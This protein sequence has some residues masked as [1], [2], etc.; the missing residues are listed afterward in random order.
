MKKIKAS[1]EDIYE[2]IIIWRYINK[3]EKNDYETNAEG[4]KTDPLT[5]EE[6][7]LVDR[8]FEENYGE[9]IPYK[10]HEIYKFN[11][12]VFDHRYFPE[13]LQDSKLTRYANPAGFTYYFE[14]KNFISKI[15]QIAGVKT[16]EVVLYN[17]S[18]IFY[19]NKNQ[20]VSLEEAKEILVGETD[21]IIKPSVGSCAGQ[22]ISFVDKKS[23]YKMVDEDIFDKIL[24]RYK[25]NFLIQ[26]LIKP[27]KSFEILHPDSINTIRL[28]TYFCNGKVEHIPAVL[29]MGV[30][31][32]RVDNAGQGGILTAV[33]DS[34]KL[35]NY[36]INEY[37]TADKMAE[38]PDTGV[39]FEKHKLE[40]FD[41]IIKAGEKMHCMVPQLGI[42]NWD[43]TLDET[44]EPV[45]IEANVDRG[46]GL[47]MSQWI[48]GKAPF[49][50]NTAKILKWISDVSKMKKC[51]R[52][53]KFVHL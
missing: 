53:R 21:L 30:G 47:G 50:E 9:K 29:R 28:V 7:Q 26:R 51:D 52:E 2:R 45:L 37:C 19:N 39:N 25:D 18:G 42:I 33:D 1:I 4:F 35:R 13:F 15:A 24:D 22:G 8:L 17:N 23:E 48:S 31:A 41:R 32:S 38:H 34:G 27:H 10:W 12:G 3:G 46:H 5:E 43:F 11:S 14:D 20:I 36:A 40:H 16:P 49:G 44:G 6:R